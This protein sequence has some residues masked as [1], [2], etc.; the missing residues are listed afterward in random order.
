MA[1]LT[2]DYIVTIVKQILP[3]AD[4]DIFDDQLDILVGGAIS[5]LSSE[6]VDIYAKEKNGDYIFQEG[7]NKAYDY[8]ICIGYQVLKDMDLDVDM[9]FMT[10]QYITRIN[11]LR[12]YIS[13]KQR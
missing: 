8:C 9:N 6:G 7:N 2:N 10:E 13:M 11:T 4:T 12:C 3:I 1:V 5:K